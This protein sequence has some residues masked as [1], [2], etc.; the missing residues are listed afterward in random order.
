MYSIRSC[1]TNVLG[2]FKTFCLKLQLNACLVTFWINIY[3][4]KSFIS[5]TLSE[6]NEGNVLK[7]IQTTMATYQIQSAPIHSNKIREDF[8]FFIIRWSLKLRGGFNI[9]S[10]WSVSKVKFRIKWKYWISPFCSPQNRSPWAY[11]WGI[12][13]KRSPWAKSWF[14]DLEHYLPCVH[15]VW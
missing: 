5:S 12:S 15:V 7:F 9:G 2:K 14:F 11:N 6:P 4:S 13:P 1:S 8:F 3:M 10:Q